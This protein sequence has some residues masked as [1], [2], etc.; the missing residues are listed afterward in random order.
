MSGVERS[1]VALTTFRIATLL[2]LALAATASAQPCPV[3]TASMDGWVRHQNR[4]F[5][6]EILGP[7]SFAP[8]DWPN[9]LDP[10]IALFSLWANAATTVDF[11]GPTDRTAEHI[12]SVTGA[13]CVLTTA[14]GPVRLKMWRHL[15][16]QYNGR[17][18]TYFDAGG[19]ITLLGRPPM[20]VGLSAH[21][22]LTLLG[23]LQILQ[24]LKPLTPE[25]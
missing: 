22:S 11:V 21:D 25:P 16:V 3:A 18:T 24:T 13:G 9:R 23:S 7:P 15:G 6:L 2:A 8:K 17:D 4:E 1:C 12:R 19:E 14:A 10:S 5:G 20:F